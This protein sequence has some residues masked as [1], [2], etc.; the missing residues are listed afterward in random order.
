MKFIIKMELYPYC[1]LHPYTAKS[2]D[3]ADLDGAHNYAI[4]AVKASMAAA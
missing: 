3:G 2:G 4:A 1:I